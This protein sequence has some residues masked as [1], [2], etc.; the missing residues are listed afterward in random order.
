[1]SK[2]SKVTSAEENRPAILGS[3]EGECADSNITNLNGLDITREVWETVFASDDYKTAIDLGHYIGFLGHPEDPNCM[4]FEHACIVMKEG[5]IDDDGKVQGKFDLIDT[6]V[7]RIVK[8]FIDAGVQFGISV[9]GAGDI[10]NNSVD[11]DT[12]VFRGFDLVAFPAFPESIP[13]FTQV[14]AS[15]KL[16]DRK[17]YKS[18]CSAVNDN[19]DALNTV[20]SV[21]IL[22]SH[23]AEQSDEYRKLEDKKNELESLEVADEEFDETEVLNQKIEGITDLYLDEVAKNKELEG[24]VESL[25]ACVDSITKSKN[26]IARKINSIKRITS[27]QARDIESKSSVDERRYNMIKNKFKDLESEY[28]HIKASRDDINKKLDK[29]RDNNLIYKQKVE[30]STSLISDKD[31]K[32]SK[33]QRKLDETVAEASN[34]EDR[35]SNLDAANKKLRS[36]IKA[37]RNLLEGYQDAYAELYSTACGIDIGS[38]SV[39]A[40]TSVSELRDYIS[41][42]VNSGR[43]SYVEADPTPAE[44]DVDSLGY[45]DEG[46]VTL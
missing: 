26:Q 3:F 13:T 37:C 44:I 11:P 14:A 40:S 17:K 30:S 24:E 4:D 31:S 22:Q 43:S 27:A 39:T 21:S 29:L 28:R 45:D 16:E 42:S 23:F 7:G 35:A 46:L 33:L 32:I 2:K 8:T 19:I 36:E 34:L 41:S 10:I 5:H 18:I 9:R 12:F 1:M 6:P 15:T 20:E 38:L 25:K